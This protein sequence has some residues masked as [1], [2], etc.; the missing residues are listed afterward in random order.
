MRSTALL[1]PLVF[2]LAAVVVGTAGCA[3]A[4]SGGSPGIRP[5]LSP[6]DQGEV[7]DDTTVYDTDV[8]AVAR[9]DGDL[10]AA[11]TAASDR[12]AGE[13]ITLRINSGW[14]SPE[15]QERLLRDA[16]STY[17]S[18]DEASRWVATPETSAHVSGDAVDVGPFDGAYWLDLHGAEFGLC[19]TYVNEPWHFELRPDA[20]MVGCPDQYLDPTEDPR[21][22]G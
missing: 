16:V 11:L 6:I 1:A 9:L 21:M 4:G 14:R 5:A 8:P 19:R 17:G 12:A 22:A 13:D 20:P 18:L 3:A 15:M 10:R 7:P 2:V